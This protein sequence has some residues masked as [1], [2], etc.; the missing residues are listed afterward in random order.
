MFL[1]DLNSGNN[2]IINI[3]RVLVVVLKGSAALCIFKK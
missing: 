1:K 3:V 2:L